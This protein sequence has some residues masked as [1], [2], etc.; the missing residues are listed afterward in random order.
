MTQLDIFNVS[1]DSQMDK[2]E[3]KWRLKYFYFIIISPNEF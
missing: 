3:H 1:T 2:L